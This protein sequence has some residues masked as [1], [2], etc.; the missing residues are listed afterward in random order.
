MF[1]LSLYETAVNY[2]P[3]SQDFNALFEGTCIGEKLMVGSVVCSTYSLARSLGSEAGG[4]LRRDVVKVG[5]A[6]SL[7]AFGSPAHCTLLGLV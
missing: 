2:P 3:L 5:I 6:S 1:S 4:M 7:I